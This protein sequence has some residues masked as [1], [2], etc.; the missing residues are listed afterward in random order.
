MSTMTDPVSPLLS[1]VHILPVEAHPELEEGAVCHSAGQRSSGS[2]CSSAQ[3][4]REEK[5][6]GDARKGGTED[7]GNT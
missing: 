3:E 2:H 5:E 4:A 1:A 6:A 7:S